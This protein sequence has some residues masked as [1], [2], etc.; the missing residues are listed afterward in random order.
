MKSIF[1]FILSFSTLLIVGSKSLLAQGSGDIVIRHVILSDTVLANS[2]DSIYFVVK[3]NSTNG[4]D[5]FSSN[6]FYYNIYIDSSTSTPFS[7]GLS[8]IISDSVTIPSNLMLP[9][10]SFIVSRPISIPG[11]AAY[12]MINKDNEV[13]IWPSTTF[14][15]DNYNN[16]FAR[17]KFYFKA[18]TGIVSITN[19]EIKISIVPNPTHEELVLSLDEKTK[20]S[21]Y[22]VTVFK[23]DGSQIFDTK[24]MGNSFTANLNQIGATEKGMYLLKLEIGGKSKIM[25]FVVD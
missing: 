3:N 4:V 22:A 10:D 12:A 21:F 19:D 23:M 16:N 7:Y 15:D 5:T 24:F 9:G 6:N 14:T 11:G 2:I 13:I 18:A 8:P 25:K 17:R 20:T 1:K